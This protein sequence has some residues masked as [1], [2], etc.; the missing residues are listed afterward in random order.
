MCY[1]LIRPPE[2]SALSES[3]VRLLV[4]YALRR[5]GRAH[6]PVISIDAFRGGAAGGSFVIARPSGGVEVRLADYIYPFLRNYK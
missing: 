5:S 1:I 3:A 6:W 2:R 4:N